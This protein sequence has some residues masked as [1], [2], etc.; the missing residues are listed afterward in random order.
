MSTE[1]EELWEH[2]NIMLGFDAEERMIQKLPQDFAGKVVWGSRY[3]HHDA[4]SAW[5]HWPACAWPMCLSR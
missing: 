1:P 4:T 2:G 5:V 3:P